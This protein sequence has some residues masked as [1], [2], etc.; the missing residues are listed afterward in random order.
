MKRF[1]LII[2]PLLSAGNVSADINKSVANCATKSGDLE[3][4]ECYDNVSAQYK[5]NTPVQKSVPTSGV[6]K[7]IVSDSVNPVDDSRTV[8]LALQ[9]DS[10]QS[11]WGKPITLVLRCQSNTTNLYINWNDYLGSEAE[12]LTRVGN[13]KA[14]TSEWSISTDK[15]S[16]FYP[17]S[18]IAF[19]RSLFETDKLVAQVTPYNENPVTAIFNISGLR[20]AALPLMETCNWS[21]T[22]A[23][24]E[25]EAADKKAKECDRATQHLFDLK[26]AGLSGTAQYQKVATVVAQCKD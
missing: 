10:G 3:R 23:F 4:L 7:W 26:G 11:K 20:K 2:L 13:A 14:S 1:A 16:S 12:V 17:G 22:K 24:I 8:T 25:K 18:S 21:D 19:I 6:G 15:Q 5:L 9:A